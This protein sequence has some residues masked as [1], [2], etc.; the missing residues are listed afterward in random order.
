MKKPLPL[1]ASLK[2]DVGVIHIIGIGGIGMSGI[3]ELLHNLGFKVQGSDLNK[4][5]NVQRLTKLGI[6]IFSG[7]HQ[8]SN[9]D[10]ADVIVKSSAVQ[11]NNPEIIAARQNNI[12]IVRR[13]EMLAE[14]M[15]LKISIA[16][17]GTHG[18]TTTTTM[19]TTLLANAG[20]NPTFINGGIINAFGTNAHLG[21][22]EYM[23][24][25]AD[26]SDGT[27]TKLPTTVAVVTNIEPEHLDFFG[28]FNALKN[29]FEEFIDNIPFYGFAV[30]CIDHPEVQNL[31][32]KVIDKRIITYGINPQAD[33]R[34][35]NIRKTDDGSLFDVSIK[36]DDGVIEIKDISLAMPGTHN[37]ANSL[38]AIALAHEI[39]ITED[40]IKQALLNFEGVKRRFT[41]LGEV[42][43]ITYID[44]YAHH[45]TEIAATLQAG[46]AVAKGD[47][48]AVMQPHRYTR[49]QDLFADFCACFN[50]ADKVIITPLYEAGE[51]PI[52]GISSD[53]LAEGARTAGH[54]WVRSVAEDKIASTIANEA[55]PGDY[56]IFM[57][58]GTITNIAADIFGNL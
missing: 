1:A 39:G 41:K 52:D 34:G 20:L 51:E 23:I 6:T 36:T 44:D 29:A 19:I 31:I 2:L 43:G 46:R 13:R 10:N 26:E 7:K 55:K 27:F 38:A 37:L 18:K 32:G 16:V 11:D 15:R 17:A 24:V 35:H 14:L 3:A 53:T 58:A 12:P 47:V 21:D 56:V 30:M 54:K 33:V 25:E 57:G 9:V 42:N 40:K 22:G 8:A 48:I 5:A 45:P 50:N 28:S 4:N 49:L